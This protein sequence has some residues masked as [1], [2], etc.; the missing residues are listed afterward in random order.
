MPTG[1]SKS[2]L[3][4]G[5]CGLPAAT[6]P[7]WKSLFSVKPKVCAPMAFSEPP[8]VDG[9]RVI[10]PPAEA[11][12]E[13]VEMWEGSLVGQ[14]FDKGLPL[15]VVRSIVDRLWGKHGIPEISTTDGMFIFRFRDREARDWVLENGPWYFAGKLMILR[16]WKPGMETL[17]A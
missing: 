10:Q 4:V 11:V 6:S 16:M 3:S 17:N 13:G 9:Q 5:D 14:F 12:L 1:I 8:I 15:H 2:S 7:N